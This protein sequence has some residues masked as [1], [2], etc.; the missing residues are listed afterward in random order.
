[1]TGCEGDASSHAAHGI[2]STKTKEVSDYSDNWR[3]GGF[4]SEL[5]EGC[6]YHLGS[7]W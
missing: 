2:P 1:M 3:R 6:A 5:Q 7:D 4:L